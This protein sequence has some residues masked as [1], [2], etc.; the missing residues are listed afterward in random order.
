M[1]PTESPHS[2]FGSDLARS[3]AHLV[4]VEPDDLGRLAAEFP[5][6]VEHS[7]REG[8]AERARDS[9][10]GLLGDL[11]KQILD[12]TQGGPGLAIVTGAGLEQLSDAELRAMLYGIS[13]ELGRP[14]AQNPQGDRIVSVRDEQPA[15][16]T[17]RG[18]RTNHGLRMHTDPADVAGLLCL[19]Q[20]IAGGANVFASAEAVHDVL[21]YEAPALLHE[22]YRLWDWD[23]AGQQREGARPTLTS[24]IFS[25]YR[26][27]LSCRYASRLLRAAPARIGTKLTD[28]QV[29]ALDR[30]EDVAQRPAL[31]LTHSLRRGESMWLNNYA[32]LHG[33]EGFT[34]GTGSGEVR[35]LLRTWLWL[36]EGPALA[37]SFAHPERCTEFSHPVDTFGIHPGPSRGLL[38]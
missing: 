4:F 3:G 21:A 19:S 14:R 18:S 10:K 29:E 16:S 11:A 25:Y 22:Y 1:S 20:G 37:P 12:R 15:D 17:A 33:R 36:H 27:H 5:N 38:L 8:S 31:Q 2:W 26:G 9:A 34:D 6:H 28:R 24:P 13:L 30:F 7:H 35:H 32:V 23:L